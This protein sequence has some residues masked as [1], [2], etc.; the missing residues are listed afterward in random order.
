VNYL[1]SAA[2]YAVAT[3]RQNSKSESEVDVFSQ[4]GAVRACNSDPP[5]PNN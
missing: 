2:A 5:N 4:P 3:V 1:L